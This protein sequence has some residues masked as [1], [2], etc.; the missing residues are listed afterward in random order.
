MNLIHHVIFAYLE[1]IDS[2]NNS[3][4]TVTDVLYLSAHLSCPELK[5]GQHLNPS[6]LS[7]RA[8]K[9][10]ILITLWCSTDPSAIKTSNCIQ[11]TRYLRYRQG[12]VVKSSATFEME[13]RPVRFICKG[14]NFH[15]WGWAERPSQPQIE[16]S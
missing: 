1:V 10:I 4:T 13:S 6:M 9:H 15:F 8:T 16:A 12:F 3:R 2:S 5:K 7:R 11:Y 14:L